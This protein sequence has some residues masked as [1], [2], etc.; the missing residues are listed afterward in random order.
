[1]KPEKNIKI[2]ADIHRL[3]AVFCAE[4]EIKMKAFASE[5]IEK[6]IKKSIYREALAEQS[7]EPDSSAN[8][9]FD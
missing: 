5:A 6:H 2:D 1:M 7:S 4:R 3:L 9:Q 8:N